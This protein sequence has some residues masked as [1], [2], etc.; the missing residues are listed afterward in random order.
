MVP[1]DKTDF[2]LQEVSELDDSIEKNN[3]DRE[4]GF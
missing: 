4:E 2:D 3:V 1:I